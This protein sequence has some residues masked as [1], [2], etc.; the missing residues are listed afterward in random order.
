[1]LPTTVTQ[2]EVVDEVLMVTDP[3]LVVAAVYVG[4]TTLAIGSMKAAVEAVP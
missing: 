3:Q 4:T 2:P 1:L